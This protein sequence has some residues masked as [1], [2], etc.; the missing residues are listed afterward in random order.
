MLVHANF[1][2]GQP[3]VFTQEQNPCHGYSDGIGYRFR[4][5]DSENFIRQQGWKDENQRYQ[6]NHLSQQS[7]EYGSKCISQGYEGLLTGD[8]DPEQ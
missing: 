6:Q 1:F 4:Q 5:K 2:M 8:L 7:Q 3:L